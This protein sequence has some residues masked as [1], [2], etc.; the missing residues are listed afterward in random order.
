MDNIIDPFT[1]GINPFDELDEWYRTRKAPPDGDY[2]ASE[3]ARER[4]TQRLLDWLERNAVLARYL[5]HIKGSSSRNTLPEHA[6]GERLYAMMTLALA[7]RGDVRIQRTPFIRSPTGTTAS[8]ELYFQRCATGCALMLLKAQVYQWSHPMEKLAD[9]SPLPPHTVNRNILQMPIMFW[10][11][12]TRYNFPDP[13]GRTGSNNW[14][15]LLHQVDHVLILGDVSYHD[16]ETTQL[17]I[18]SISYDLVWPNDYDNDP[19]VGR[20]LKRCAFLSSPFVVTERRRMTH[21][22]RRQLERDHGITREA[23]N[24]PEANVVTLRRLKFKAPQPSSHEGKDVEWKHHWWV[25]QHY[26]AQWYPSEKAH[27]VIWVG[28][29]IKGDLSKPLLEKVYAVVR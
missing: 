6:L 13:Q 26:R 11:R 19:H 1:K 25:S 2:T 14:L 10:S 22:A 7:G 27:R 16:D 21:A 5:A 3:A 29:H 20:L 23:A 24:E 15:A 28:P 4:T 9:A 12:E 17:L 18:D 8:D